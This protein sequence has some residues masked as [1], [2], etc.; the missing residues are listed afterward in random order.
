[1][2]ITDARPIVIVSIENDIPENLTV[3]SVSSGSET[4]I[5]FVLFDNLFSSKKVKNISKTLSPT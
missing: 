4:F 2:I 1:M 5:I 3:F